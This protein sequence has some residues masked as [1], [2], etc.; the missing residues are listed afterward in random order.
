MLQCPECANGDMD[1]AINEWEGEEAYSGSL[2]CPYCGR[3][4]AIDR[5]IPRFVAE[6]NYANSFGYQWGRFART[7]LDSFSERT[8]SRDRFVRQIGYLP[9]SLK[10][11]KVLDI[12]CGAGR[13]SEVAL[14]LGAEVY[15]VD[16]SAAVDACLQNLSFHP[17]LHVLQADLY[18]TPLKPKKFD[19]VYCFGCLQHTP[20]VRRAFFSLVDYVKEG[21]RL[22][23]DI[24]PKSW[25]NWFWCKY[26]LR[27]LTIHFPHRVLLAVI[28][29]MIPFLLPFSNVLSRLPKGKHIRHMLPIANYK[30]IYP[31]NDQQL[32]EW[33]VLDTFDM[34]SARYDYPQ[35]VETIRKWFSEAGFDNIEV[36]KDGLVIGRGSQS[37]S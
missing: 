4:Y 16:Y 2:I 23:V 26:W 37:T 9:A 15:A 8:I 31:L 1:L 3:K 21:G 32:R 33:A 17:K 13:F 35:T 29:E 7:Q 6:D 14:N 18:A 22:V 11:S 34:L 30:D 25:K 27:P 20:D 10:G 24:Y 19:F 28:E 5:S 36:F 12:G